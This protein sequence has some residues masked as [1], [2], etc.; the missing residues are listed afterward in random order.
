[1]RRH[2]TALC[3]V[4]VL[5]VTSGC[6][7]AL[8]GDEKTAAANLATSFAGKDPSKARVQVARCF[9]RTMVTEAGLSQL[10]KDK[11]INADLT[12]AKMVPKT[13]S[14]DTAEA[15]GDG[16]VDCFDFSKLKGDV[17]KD[18]GASDAQVTSYVTCLDKIDKDDLKAAIVDQYTKTRTTAVRKRV[19]AATK[20]CGKKLGA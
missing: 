18:S 8:R 4:V 15:Y 12:A 9:G 10:K 20:A 19:D 5:L 17:K 3:A 14:Q 7:D 11:V 2:V 16:L 6:G 1:M 13:L